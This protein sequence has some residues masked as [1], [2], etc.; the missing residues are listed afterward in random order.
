MCNTNC[1]C[2]AK[3][4]VKVKPLYPDS[5]IPKQAD[6]G[7]AGH[8]IRAYFINN[9]YSVREPNPLDSS[10]P[11]WI[12]KQASDCI[13][14]GKKHQYIDILPKQQVKVG[15]GIATQFSEDMVMKI[16]PRSSAGIKQH[17]RLLNTVGIIDS[18]Y[19]QEIL[20]FIENTSSEYTVRILHNERIAQAIFIP[21]V[22]V[23][24]VEVMELE[25]TERTG[26]VGSSGKL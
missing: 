12:P 20:M 24:L 14:E 2:K 5:E 25:A 11:I 13:I 18:S 3:K 19:T 1:K 23:E 10:K 21:I 16:Y 7:S 22:N 8:D 4:V 9:K 17:L 26:G 15:T 6:S